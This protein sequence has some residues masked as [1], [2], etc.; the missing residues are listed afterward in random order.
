MSPIGFNEIS[1]KITASNRVF[2]EF[3]GVSITI[4]GF[5]TEF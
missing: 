1:L 5:Y 4:T 3:D 2:V